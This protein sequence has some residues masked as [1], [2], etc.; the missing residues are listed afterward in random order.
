MDS[1]P[2]TTIY[3]GKDIRQ[4]VVQRRQ[5]NRHL[6]HAQRR[7]RRGDEPIDARQRGA[8]PASPA[9]V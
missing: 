8:H 4:D 1:R 2:S 5:V 7:A 6:H 3:T 9:R